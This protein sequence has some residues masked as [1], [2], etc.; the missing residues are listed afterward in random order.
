MSCRTLVACAS[1]AMVAS[2]DSCPPDYHVIK[3]MRVLGTTY[4]PPIAPPDGTVTVRAVTADVEARALTVA[5]YRCPTNLRLTAIATVDGSFDA[6]A[7]AAP[8]LATGEF[9]RGTSVRVPVN[10]DGGTLDAVPYRTRRRWTDLVGFACAD[11]DIEAPP[12]G[13]LWPRCT[14]AR[15]VVFTASIPGPRADGSDAAPTPTSIEGITFAGRA[16]GA[17]AVPS[18]ARCDGSR[19]T[20]PSVEITFQVADAA[21]VIEPTSAGNGVLGAPDDS[22]VFVGYHVT[23]AATASTEYCQNPDSDAVIQ[24]SDGVARLAWVPPS[25]AGDVTFWFTARRYSGALTV[26]RRSARVE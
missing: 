18:V 13:G 10:A 24:A 26:V 7:I 9:A 14:G 19:A 25:D 8:C 6:S 5:W 3:S 2:C 16:W 17:N 1:L 4:D 12:K 20:C 15:G 11:G 22:V 23:G 21:V